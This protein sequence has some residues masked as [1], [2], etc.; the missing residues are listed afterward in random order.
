ME[1]LPGGLKWCIEEDFAVHYWGL[2]HIKCCSSMFPP[3]MSFMPRPASRGRP[4]LTSSLLF[5]PTLVLGLLAVNFVGFDPPCTA[6]WFCSNCVVLCGG[7]E[8]ND[9]VSGK[10][11]GR[12]GPHPRSL[13]FEPIGKRSA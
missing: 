1:Y 4:A 6:A 5:L 7:D 13:L 11:V 2:E 9:R 10:R 3:S 12:V 8:G